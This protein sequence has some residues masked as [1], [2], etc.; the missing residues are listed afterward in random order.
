[1][2]LAAGLG[3]RLKPLTDHTPK[4]LLRAGQYTLLEF[5]IKKLQK[6]GFNDLIINIHHCGRMVIDYLQE[7]N[8]FGSNVTI[9]DE[10]DRLLDTGGAIRKVEHFFNDDKPFIVYNADIISNID[11]SSLYEY[12]LQTGGLATLVVRRRETSR[13]LMFDELMQL[14]EWQ[15]KAKGLSKIVRITEK[16]P[17]AFAFSGIH[18]ISPEIFNML[19]HAEVFSIID[20]YLEIAK[21][22]RIVGFVDES[23]LF[24]DAGKPDS[25]AEAG[26]IASEI[27]L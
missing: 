13:Y 23:S 18:V 21:V 1:M 26:R 3:T 2:I 25:L 24:A 19:P 12:H 7:H 22:H 27:L 5:A 4:V 8:N 14:T 10:T 16:P 11:L 9:S 15:N 17:I 20:A 6:Y